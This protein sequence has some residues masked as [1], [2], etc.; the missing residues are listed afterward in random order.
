MNALLHARDERLAQELKDDLSLQSLLKQE[1]ELL[2]AQAKR[3][4]EVFAVVATLADLEK[5]NEQM[6]KQA[7][8]NLECLAKVATIQKVVQKMQEQRLE[9]QVEFS[10]LLHQINALQDEMHA[11]FCADTCDALSKNS[12]TLETHVMLHLKKS[13]Q[14]P[15]RFAFSYK[16]FYEFYKLFIRSTACNKASP[17]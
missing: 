4:L 1:A 2:E 10:Q 6:Q 9:R 16:M 15:S 14:T 12:E 13:R 5:Q 8:R 17:R 11:T 3:N 7:T